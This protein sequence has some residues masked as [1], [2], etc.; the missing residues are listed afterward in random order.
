MDESRR[1]SAPLQP[2]MFHQHQS[3]RVEMYSQNRTISN[4]GNNL[5]T[6]GDRPTP[7]GTPII[8]QLDTVNLMPMRRSWP[9]MPPQPPKFTQPFQMPPNI[10]QQC[11]TS[12]SQMVSNKINI[13]FIS[14]FSGSINRHNHLHFIS[15]CCPHH[16]RL[17]LQW[18]YR[19]HQHH[20]NFTNRRWTMLNENW[21]GMEE[22]IDQGTI[23]GSGKKTIATE[24]VIDG[25]NRS[26]TRTSG[27]DLIKNTHNYD[28]L[29]FY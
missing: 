7:I 2:Q 15:G 29:K 5:M 11:S 25:S 12:S 10:Q 18:E 3:N 8:N 26:H 16:R 1:F 24:V 21:K 22:N 14:F 19:R 17:L 27:N 13:K 20:P 9:Q 28:I 23:K 6:Y 4:V